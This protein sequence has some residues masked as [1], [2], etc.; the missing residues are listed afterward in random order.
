MQEFGLDITTSQPLINYR[1]TIRTKA[2]PVMSKSP[3]K[4]NKIFMRVEALGE[5]IVEMINWTHQ[6]RYGQ[7]R[8]GQVT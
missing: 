3:N 5:D 6:R 1:E 4:H 7:E 8:N 2:G